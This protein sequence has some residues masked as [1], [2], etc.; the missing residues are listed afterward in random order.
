MATNDLLQDLRKEL[1]DLSVSVSDDNVLS[2][3]KSNS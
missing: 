2:S 1:D 3:C